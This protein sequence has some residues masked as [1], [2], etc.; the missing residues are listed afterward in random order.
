MRSLCAAALV[1]T[2]A[3]CISGC[4]PG[5]KTKLVGHFTATLNIVTSSPL[6][7]EPAGENY[8][9]VIV[10]SGGEPSYTWSASGLPIGW[11]MQ[12][13]AGLIYA[14]AIM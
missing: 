8:R 5:N 1:A 6:P 12:P 9:A 13:A 3:L 14:S 7:D 10:A 11:A 4:K 2:L